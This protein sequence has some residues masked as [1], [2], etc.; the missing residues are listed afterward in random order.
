MKRK[1]FSILFVV[2]LALSLSLVTAVP[3]GA[4]GPVGETVTIS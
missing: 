1:I 2:V 4:K 3:A